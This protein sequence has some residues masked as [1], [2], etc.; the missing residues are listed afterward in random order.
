M[1]PVDR[2]KRAIAYHAIDTERQYQEERWGHQGVKSIDEYALYI[3]G[4]ANALTAICSVSDNAETRL[5]A[6]RKVAGL[7]VACFEQHGVP[8]REGVKVVPALDERVEA[9]HKRAIKAKAVGMLS[10]PI[11]DAEYRDLVEAK[12]DLETWAAADGRHVTFQSYEGLV[13]D[14]LG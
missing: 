2:A 14:R 3:Q 9:I 6:M 4:Y 8:L 5:A 13:L 10:F 1:M 11:T 7:C 12:V